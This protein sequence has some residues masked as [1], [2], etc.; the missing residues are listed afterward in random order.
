MTIPEGILSIGGA[1]FANCGSLTTVTLPSTLTNIGENAF[2]GCSNLTSLTIPDGLKSIGDA[3]FYGCQKL[4]NMTIPNS[5]IN[6]GESAFYGCS[7]LFSV[8]IPS[9]LIII[10]RQTF[11][12]CSNLS[13]I[14]IPASVEYIYQEA[15]AHCSSLIQIDA[16]PEKPT[17]LFDNSFSDFSVLVKVPK[18]CKE[19]YMAAQGWKNFTI[20]NDADKYKLIYLV[21][22]EEYRS[23]EVDFGSI[24]T[25]E[26]PP[27]KEGYTFSGWSEIPEI[28]RSVDIE[29]RGS[30]TVNKYK[31]TYMIDG[32]VYKTEEVEYGATITPPNPEDRSGYD[33]TWGDYPSTMPDKD[34]TITGS[35]TVGIEAILATESDVKIYTV[36]GK[37][38]KKL[39][40]GVNIIRTRDGKTKKVVMK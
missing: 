12:R 13:W 18:G 40:K 26:A 39:Q 31:V 25:P 5:V 29:I 37:P 11:C 19:A 2:S 28:M 24:I 8:T 23:E 33:F 10:K 36:S 16:Q 22:G 7:G 15:F 9:N 3:A 38:I 21:D 30:F 27:K 32:E 4:T 1:T 34:I 6:I 17:F 20:I 35:Y 14:T